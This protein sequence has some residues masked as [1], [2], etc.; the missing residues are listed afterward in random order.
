MKTFQLLLPEEKKPKITLN[1]QERF[2]ESTINLEL[3]AFTLENPTNQLLKRVFELMNR[4]PVEEDVSW[5]NIHY[6]RLKAKELQ[7]F[8]LNNIQD[9]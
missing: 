2:S 1:F 7:F 3:K 5:K 4:L 9:C 8:Y 6:L